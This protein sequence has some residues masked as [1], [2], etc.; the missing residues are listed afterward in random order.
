MFHGFNALEKRTTY[1]LRHGHTVYIPARVLREVGGILFTAACA[2]HL[3][4]HLNVLY[5]QKDEET[6]WLTQ[7]PVGALIINSQVGHS[8][9]SPATSCCLG[10]CTGALA[11]AAVSCSSNTLELVPLAIQAVRLV[12]R[13]RIWLITW[14]DVL[15]LGEVMLKVVKEHQMMR[16]EALFGQRLSGPQ[17]LMS[18]CRGHSW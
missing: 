4:W 3:R 7:W 18:V 14:Q 17:P 16:Q 13:I 15:S 9:P 11:A 5:S 6:R 12:F 1:V 8:Y 2:H 10:F